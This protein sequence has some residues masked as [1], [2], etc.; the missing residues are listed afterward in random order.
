GAAANLLA[1][2][3]A[4]EALEV[5]WQA[6]EASAQLLDRFG[7][8]DWGAWQQGYAENASGIAE[9]ARKALEGFDGLWAWAGF[10]RA[11]H[12]LDE[13]GL[14]TLT[15]LVLYG[16]LSGSEVGPASSFLFYNSIAR[17]I[18]RE[19]PTLIEFSGLSHE[20]LRQA[21][22]ELDK[23]VIELNGKHCAHVIDQRAKA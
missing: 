12:R 14:S 15:A 2:R 13:H 22:A 23:E 18:L 7:V 11:R 21:F 1:L 6:V 10:R 16:R 19:N 5:K 17:A 8:L 20:Q 3:A 9:R 4:L